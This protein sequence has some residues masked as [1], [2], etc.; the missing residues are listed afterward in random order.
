MQSL[1]DFGRP[2]RVMGI[3]VARGLAVIGMIGAHVGAQMRDE[4]GE[5]V[6]FDWGASATWGDIVNGRSA[7]L[8]AII[9]GVSIAIL[10]RRTDFR[11]PDQVR[12]LR[13]QMLG[14]GVTVFAIG[15]VL[16]L[17]NTGAAII[18]SV[19]GALFVAAIPFLGLRRRAIVA[20]AIGLAILGPALLGVLSALSL[21]ASGPGMELVLFGNYPLTEWLGLMLAGLAVGRSR[22]ERASVALGLLVGG[23]LLAT[24]GYW[25]G[26]VAETWLA[27]VDWFS[28]SQGSWIATLSGGDPESYWGMVAATQPEE[29]VMWA[30]LGVEP[31]SGGTPEIVGSGGFA[32]AVLGL[33]LLLARPLR[34]PLIPVAALGSMPLTAYSAHIVVILATVG[35]ALEPQENNGLW[36]WMTVGLLVATTLWAVL[37]GKG[38]LEQ[39]TGWASRLMAHPAPARSRPPASEYA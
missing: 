17:L 33:C 28:V 31:H 19:Y 3:D 11:D 36:L 26:A 14:R 12:T 2:P 25:L 20:W 35:T 1:R 8:F 37:R 9:A 4:F 18:L 32:L 34:V 10:S 23:V 22:P 27:S 7:I 15:T 5:A 30:M 39:L 29:T 21:D 13:L 6:R 24:L 16:E 38:P